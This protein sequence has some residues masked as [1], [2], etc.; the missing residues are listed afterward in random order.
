MENANPVI[1]STTTE[2]VLSA[3]NY[4]DNIIDEIDKSEIFGI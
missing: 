4:N 1:H 3:D 2:L